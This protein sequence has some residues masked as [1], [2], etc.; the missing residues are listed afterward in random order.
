NGQISSGTFGSGNAGSLSVNVVSALTIDG[1]KADP[2]FRTGLTTDGETGSRGNA[3]SL[4]VAAGNLSVVNG[5]TISSDT[6]GPGAAGNVTVTAGA[7]RLANFGA[8]S[9]DTNGRGNGG[10]VTITAGILSIGPDGQIT[11]DTTNLG[12]GGSI[13]VNVAG[14]LSIDG[15]SATGPT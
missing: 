9:S 8:V 5:G 7:M 10:T 15:V 1:V 14:A 3:G 6:N 12:N 13:A 2:N 4:T 11:T